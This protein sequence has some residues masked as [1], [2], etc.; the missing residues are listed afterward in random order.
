MA[1]NKP[2]SDLYEDHESTIPHVEEHESTIT[3]VATD[4]TQ[5]D[6]DAAQSRVRQH[7]MT[8]KGS[9]LFYEQI[10]KY[11]NKLAKFGENVAV[12]DFR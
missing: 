3:H 6:R 1:S 2:Q 5:V 4:D 11:N 12:L 7:T 8:E 9:A 10:S